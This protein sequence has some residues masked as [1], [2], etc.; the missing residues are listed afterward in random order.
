M[1]N[2][3]GFFYIFIFIFLF[4]GVGCSSEQTQSAEFAVLKQPSLVVKVYETGGNNPTVSLPLLMWPSFESRMIN[5]YAHFTGGGKSEHCLITES[6]G[7]Q[8][9]VGTKVEVLEEATCL[10]VLLNS[11]DEKPRP[12]SITLMQIRLVETGEEG[13]TWSKAI[14]F[15]KK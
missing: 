15:D 8:L 14:E 2:I 5:T 4:S 11:N 3:K 1:L 12:Y 13:W 6:E 9:E 10:Y 7:S